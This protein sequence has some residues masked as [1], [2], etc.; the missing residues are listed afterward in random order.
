MKGIKSQ[1]HDLL[2]YI[3]ML[4][5]DECYGVLAMPRLLVQLC[6]VP[7]YTACKQG[8]ARW[9]RSVQTM[10]CAFKYTNTVNH[11]EFRSV[12]QAIWVVECYGRFKHCFK[13]IFSNFKSSP[14]YVSMSKLWIPTV[15]TTW[16]LTYC[17]IVIICIKLT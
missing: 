12:V 6:L 1:D 13:K 17:K 16:L 7:C 5:L 4:W 2:K 11:I 10:H 15:P 8:S 9:R 14:L 3:E